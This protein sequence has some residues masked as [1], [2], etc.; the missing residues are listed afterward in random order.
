MSVKLPDKVKIG[1]HWYKV[2]FPYKFVERIDINGLTDH[3][4]V[5]IKISEGD[6]ISQKLAESKIMETFFHEIIHA[7]DY[8]YNAN[9]LDEPTVKRLAQGLYQFLTDNGLLK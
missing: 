5:E 6:G 2:L 4:T 3:D 1:G 8:I 7:I 9:S